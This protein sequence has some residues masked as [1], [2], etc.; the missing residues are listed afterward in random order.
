MVDGMLPIYDTELSEQVLEWLLSGDP[1]IVYQTH[2]DLIQNPHFYKRGE[3]DHRNLKK[4]QDRIAQEGWGRALL[5]EQGQDGLWAGAI[6]SPK[7]ISTHYTLLQ[8]MRIGFPGDHPVPQKAIKRYLDEKYYSDMGINIGVTSTCSDVCVT[9]MVLTMLC[10]Y[11]IEDERMLNLISFLNNT[12]LK[13]GGW[14]CDHLSG[15]YHSSVHTTLSVI[16]AL[17]TSRA[18]GVPTDEN[19]Q[20]LIHSGR[21]F[22]LQHNLYKSHRTGEVMKKSFTMLS[23]P[24]RWFYDVLK[25]LDYFQAFE[26]PYDKRMDDA[27]DLL[28]AKQRKN[29]RWPVQNKHAG[30][31]YFDMEKSGDSRWNTLRALRVFR[32]FSE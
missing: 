5:D 28:Y 18:S 19:L 25:A 21:E 14:N 1:S 8:M 30:R 10:Y 4:L 3:A 31:V 27:L 9:A 23:F 32:H 22:L 11:G 16:E 24:P 29:G 17:D 15:D 20:D 2:R 7:W 13:D 12:R 26:A 6:Y